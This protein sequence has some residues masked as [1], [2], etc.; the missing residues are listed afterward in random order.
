M[1]K[2]LDEAVKILA[3]VAPQDGRVLA[4]GQSLVP[5]MAFRLAKPA[6]LVDINEVEGLDR[7]ASDGKMLAIGARVR[8]GAF[9]KPVTDNPLGALLSYVAR[10]IAHY[11]IRMRGTFC[12]SCA[13]A[14]P[15]SEWC[16]TVATL[17]AVM[18]A[19]STRGE[20][21]IPARAFFAGVMST[22]LAEDELL[23]EVR[24]PLL[25]A[26]AKWGFYE[27]SRRAGDFAMSAALVT[28][29]LQGGKIVDARVGVG[30]A[31]AS[32]RRIA[33]AEAALNGQAAG[34]A[35]FR[36]AAEAAATA[37]DA[38]EDHQTSADYR[39]DLVRAV[40]RRALEYSQS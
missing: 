17:D 5:I 9:H 29:R 1:P 13:H 18:L 24:L 28:Y 15:S 26:D 12:G 3:E 35:A 4:G 7:I 30:G 34:D 37:V 32:P 11:P 38:M 33:E 27:F 39:R 14:D 23:A 2:T 40:V 31:E 21:P 36:A 6:H 22:A 16:L 25:A 10:H 20:R 19:K 8:H